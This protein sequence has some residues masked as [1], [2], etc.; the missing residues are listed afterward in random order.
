MNQVLD[1]AP[2]ISI[3]QALSQPSSFTDPTL[4]RAHAIGTTPST[5]TTPSRRR[6]KQVIEAVDLSETTPKSAKRRKTATT[7]ANTPHASPSSFPVGAAPDLAGPMA[8]RGD[9]QELQVMFG[10]YRAA[11]RNVNLWDWLEGFRAGIRPKD[12]D[13]DRQGGDE[14]VASEQVDTAGAVPTDGQKIAEMDEETA[15]RLH[16]AFVRFCEEARMIGLMRAKGNARRRGVDEVVK[17]IGLY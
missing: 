17:S 7:S 9:L 4:E 15:A 10:L 5:T 11:G 1:P 13:K 3:L 14:S 16:A 6:G 2:R 8:E 12:K